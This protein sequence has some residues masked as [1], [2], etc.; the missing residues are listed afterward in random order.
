MEFPT[1]GEHCQHEGCNQTDFLPLQCKCGKV[2]CRVH[3]LGHCQSSECEL[4]PPPREVNLKSDDQIFRCSEKGCRKGNLHEMLCAKCKKHYCIDHRFHLTCPEI[5]DKTMAAK[6]EQFVAP[7]R[8]FHEANKHL[9][10]KITENIRKALQSSAKVKTASKI[11]LMRIK[12]KAV[13]PKSVSPSERVYFAIGKPKDMEPKD[14]KIV[15]DIDS[16]VKIET[17]TL[18]PDLKDSVP[19]FICCKWSLGRAIDSICDSCNINNDNNKMGNV[20][21]RLF[22]QLDGYCIS[23][24][25]MDLEIGDLMKQDILLEGDKL[26]IEY[27]NNEV[28]SK[29][30]ENTHLFLR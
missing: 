15:D 28:L 26:L 29:I 6:I 10:E 2:L 12:Q 18:D 25:K 14:V 13:G 1:L 22:R 27:I 9:Q 20:K 16:L 11:H 8:Q 21:L 17:V 24:V 3:F 4:A 30:D 5:D 7:R 19:V 23:P